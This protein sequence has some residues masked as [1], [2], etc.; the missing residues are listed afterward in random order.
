MKIPA[1]LVNYNYDPTWLSN[2]ADPCPVLILDRSDDGVE[3][4]LSKYGKVIKTENKGNVDY[5]KLSF[6]VEQYDDLP[7]VFLWGKSN[8]LKYVD[9]PALRSA[10]ENPVFTPLLKQ[11]H[12]TYSDRFGKVCY[13]QDG[14]YHERNDSWYLQEHRPK[15]F[16]NWNEWAMEFLLPSPKYIPF[17]PGGNF[18][19]TKEKVYKYGRDFYDKMRQTMDYTQLPGEAQLAER[20]Y[21]LLWK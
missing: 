12:K 13:Y 18:I 14:L 7:D 11:D 16:N 21:Y 6:L 20:S 8:L 15:Y 9:E 10:L 2:Y 4:D 5:D 3:R 1:V 17:P 19:L